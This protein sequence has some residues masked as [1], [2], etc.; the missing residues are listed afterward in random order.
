[1][2][3]STPCPGVG[4][5]LVRL[6]TRQHGLVVCCPRQENTPK[7]YTPAPSPATVPRPS[8]GQ[9]S[10]YPRRIGRIHRYGQTME[11]TTDYSR[12]D[13][14]YF[15]EDQRRTGIGRTH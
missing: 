14:R 7:G 8:P 5:K 10:E 1:M 11:P 9:C 13:R 15:R 4:L 3:T 6:Q 12:V 2:L